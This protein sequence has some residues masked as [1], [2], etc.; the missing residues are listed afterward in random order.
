MLATLCS[1]T[2]PSE[3]QILT[4]EFSMYML[5]NKSHRFEERGEVIFHYFRVCLHVD[6]TSVV[7]C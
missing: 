3:P 4:F 6:H 1:S 5:G 2:L 7:R